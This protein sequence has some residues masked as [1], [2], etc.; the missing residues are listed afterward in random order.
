MLKIVQK[1]VPRS[2]SAVQVASNSIKIK[3]IKVETIAKSLIQGFQ[4]I[5]QIT[6]PLFKFISFNCYLTAPQS[7][8][9][10]YREDRLT[11][12]MLITRFYIFNLKVTWSLV[13]RLGPQSQ[14][15]TQCDLNRGPFDSYNNALTHQ[16]TL[17]FFH[18]RLIACGLVFYD[19]AWL[20]LTLLL[21]LSVCIFER[22]AFHTIMFSYL[23]LSSVGL[24]VPVFWE[25]LVKERGLEKISRQFPK[26]MSAIFY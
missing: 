18:D 9:G 19:M 24:R 10:H 26:I 22:Y 23:Y 13:T 3:I 14:P 4:G 5:L 21:Y 25:Q 1:Q 17:Q 16:A 2:K 8:L 11:H 12:P 7:T 6:L 15:S 20:L